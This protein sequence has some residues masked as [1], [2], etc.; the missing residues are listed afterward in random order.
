MEIT[1]YS[2]DNCSLC[3]K[4]LIILERIQKD[5]PFTIKIVNI[6]EDDALL[7]KYQIMIPVVEIEGVEV[8]AG[9]LS[10]ERIRFFFKNKTQNMNSC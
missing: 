7:E 1:Y 10:E 2:K 6:Y 4:G 5:F 3:D 9:I 8:D